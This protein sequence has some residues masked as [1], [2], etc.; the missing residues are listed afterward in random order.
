MLDMADLAW[1]YQLSMK[2]VLPSFRYLCLIRCCVVDMLFVCNMIRKLAFLFFR[3]NI[4]HLFVF[5][6]VDNE[7]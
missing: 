7:I 2:T 4:S 3:N 6:E 1:S 5:P